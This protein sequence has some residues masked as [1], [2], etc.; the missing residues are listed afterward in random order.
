VEIIETTN[1]IN[2]IGCA[3]KE[4]HGV[5]KRNILWTDSFRWK[6]TGPQNILP[7]KKSDNPFYS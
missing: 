3:L 1:I 4:T 7:V 2:K 5:K 6:F